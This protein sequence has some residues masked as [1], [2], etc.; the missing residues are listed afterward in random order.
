MVECGGH[1]TDKE[2]CVQQRG[3][4]MGHCKLRGRREGHWLGPVSRDMENQGWRGI[5][6]RLRKYLTFHSKGFA[7]YGV[8]NMELLELHKREHN[9]ISAVLYP[10]SYRGI[11][12]EVERGPWRARISYEAA[13]I[14]Q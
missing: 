3:C 5:R 14:A 10:D 6:G 13:V 11:D 4:T 8:G 1:T 9:L 2:T 7:L 12:L